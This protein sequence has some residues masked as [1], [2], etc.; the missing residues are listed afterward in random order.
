MAPL[1]NTTGAS[2]A[3]ENSSLLLRATIDWLLAVANAMPGNTRSAA[4]TPD[5][6]NK[7]RYIH[8]M[9][10]PAAAA[11]TV[12]MLSAPLSP[13][14]A[15]VV[16]L[17]VANTSRLSLEQTTPVNPSAQMQTNEP[18]ASTHMPPFRHGDDAHS[19]ISVW[20]NPPE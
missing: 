9:F 11:A 8:V 17:D 10:K 14:K 20:H 12:H 2:N 5:V 7:A 1:S 4:L 19:L 6:D 3:P 16:K 18:T 13:P 15:P